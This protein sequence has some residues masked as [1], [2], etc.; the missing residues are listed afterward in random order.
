MSRMTDDDFRAVVD[1]RLQLRRF[2]RWSE[3]AVR[4]AGLTPAQHELLLAIRYHPDSRGPTI[5]E[6]SQALALRPHSTVGLVDR[7]EAA[8]LVVRHR[9]DRD[10]RVVR[11]T[12]TRRGAQRLTGL[13][14]QHVAEIR[15]LAPAFARL[16]KELAAMQE[17]H[18]TDSPARRRP[19]RHTG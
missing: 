3:A 17:E 9:A 6:I 16:T 15:R 13:T 8:G 1:F 10:A 19:A 18:A 4:R 12:L 2:I 14:S 7:A 11:V 5:G